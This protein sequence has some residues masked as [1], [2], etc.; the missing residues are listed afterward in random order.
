MRS[1]NRMAVDQRKQ[2]AALPYRVQDG[3][4]EVMLI[5]SRETGRWII[6]KGWPLKRL[7]PRAVAAREAYEEAGLVG[8]IGKRSIGMYHY[9]KRLSPDLS[10]DCE[11]RVFLLE[12]EEEFANWPEQAD[13]GRCWLSPAQAALRVAEPELRHLLLG[14]RPK[15]RPNGKSKRRER[16]VGVKKGRAKDKRRAS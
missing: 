6:P 2:F 3:E 11:V 7:A 16:L 9:E 8:S 14:V 5:T 10:I 4:P 12:V 15:L 1:D 13:R